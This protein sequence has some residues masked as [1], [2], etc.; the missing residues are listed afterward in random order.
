MI[1][2]IVISDTHRDFNAL[3]DIVSENKHADMFIHL[4]DGEHECNDV[5][6]LF[7]DKAFLFVR[8]KTVRTSPYR[9]KF[10]ACSRG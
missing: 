1:K 9:R 6:Y 8:G 2:I 5:Q 3:H 4:G 10:T 7:P